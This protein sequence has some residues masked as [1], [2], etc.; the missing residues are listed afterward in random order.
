MITKTTML[1]VIE[2]IENQLAAL[3]QAV[4]QLPESTDLT[5]VDILIDLEKELDEKDHDLETIFNN[6]RQGW[7][8]PLEVKSDLPLL[9]IQKTMAE[10]R[11]ENWTSREVMR[12]REE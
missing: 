4:E 3:R 8:I 11:P 12:I 6:L 7:N 1:E 9:E 2:K 5:P 10:G